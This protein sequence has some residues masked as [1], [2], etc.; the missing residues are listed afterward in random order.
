MRKTD[1]FCRQCG[2]CWD[3]SGSEETSQIHQYIGSIG[4]STAPLSKEL[5]A[6]AM[7]AAVET[8]MADLQSTQHTSFSGSLVNAFTSGI[9]SR[10]VSALP[11]QTG[12][13]WRAMISALLSIP[14]W[15]MMILL[16]PLIADLALRR[17]A[18]SC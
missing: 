10:L 17:L 15:L 14:L 2:N 6:E 7:A 13:L 3:K 11:A 4:A 8:S 16:S 18:R 9:S 1:R 12:P 5:K